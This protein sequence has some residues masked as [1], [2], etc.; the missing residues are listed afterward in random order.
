LAA[1]LTGVFADFDAEVPEG[2]EDAVG[3]EVALEVDVLVWVE[4]PVEVDVLVEV[5][6]AVDVEVLVEVVVVVWELSAMSPT[7]SLAERS[8]SCPE[9]ATI[10]MSAGRR[11]SAFTAD[12]CLTLGVAPCRAVAC[13]IAGPK[14]H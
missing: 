5:E 2:E 3:A 14:P 6:V 4:V 7:R 1:V 11:R 13:A 9:M 10:G 8:I 12:L